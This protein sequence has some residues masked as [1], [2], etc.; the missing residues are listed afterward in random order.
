MTEFSLFTVLF[1][2]YTLHNV[3]PSF[4]EEHQHV[5]RPSQVIMGPGS[6]PSSQLHS[7]A[8]STFVQVP[9]PHGFPSSHSFVSEETQHLTHFHATVIC[10]SNVNMP[11]FRCEKRHIDVHR[12]VHLTFTVNSR[13]V[14]PVTEWAFTAKRPV[15][16]NAVTVGTDARILR[17]L[18][19]IWKPHHPSSSVIS[20]CRWRQ[21]THIQSLILTHRRLI[22]TQTLARSETQGCVRLWNQT[23]AHDHWSSARIPVCVCVFILYS[24]SSLPGQIS[25]G[26]PHPWPG[27][28]LQQH[29][30][31]V[32]LRGFGAR[33]RPFSNLV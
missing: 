12:D 7:N 33:Q 23:H 2:L 21:K 20:V 27:I 17:A 16:V 28:A 31:L 10:Q 22:R 3:N 19:H 18:V 6:N 30:P 24:P 5:Y 11:S 1:I 13:E 29:T 9:L 8:P 14:Q 26:S 4:K 32:V 15:C 25:Q